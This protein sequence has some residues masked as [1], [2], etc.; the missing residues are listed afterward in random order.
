VSFIIPQNNRDTE[1]LISRTKN[2]K[3]IPA[4]PALLPDNTASL[5]NPKKNMS[6]SSKSTAIG[7]G[8]EDD[9]KDRDFVPPKRPRQ[10]SEDPIEEIPLDQYGNEIVDNLPEVS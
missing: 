7:P 1:L 8:T 4:A 10:R 5:G 2:K 9:P 6:S 3:K